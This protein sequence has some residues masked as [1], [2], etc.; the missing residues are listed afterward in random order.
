MSK[1]TTENEESEDGKSFVASSSV[2]ISSGEM[3]FTSW[4]V[5]DSQKHEDFKI[6]DTTSVSGDLTELIDVAHR[7]ERKVDDV[8]DMLERIAKSLNISVSGSSDGVIEDVLEV[9]DETAMELI[10]EFMETHERAWPQ[11]ISLALRLDFGQ[12]MR[13]TRNLLKEG[14]LSDEPIG[15]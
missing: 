2:T 13:I 9:D 7:T 10:L 15:N 8:R 6:Y 3:F 11:D 5:I 12:V 14:T 4:D 1:Q